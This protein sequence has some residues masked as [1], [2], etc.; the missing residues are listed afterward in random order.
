MD[1]GVNSRQIIRNTI[2]LFD[3]VLVDSDY[4]DLSDFIK[5]FV[6]Q[7]GLY[8][9]RINPYQVNVTKAKL[10]TAILTEAGYERSYH[11]NA[12]TTLNY[13][14]STGYIWLPQAMAE[15]TRDLRLSPVWQKFLKLELFL[16]R[17]DGDVMMLSHRGDLYR[18]AIT[19][20]NYV[21]DAT[22]P[23][24]IEYGFTFEAYT[25]ELGRGR[26]GDAI[27]RLSFKQFLGEQYLP[28]ALLRGLSEALGTGQIK[29][30]IPGRVISDLI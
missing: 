13:R 5:S 3:P 16:E 24:A 12:M 27:K 30:T 23:W 22:R 8:Q 20:F 25:D 29:D 11:G 21:E 6:H 14:G 17:L 9:F 15:V 28:S 1:L 10:T 19:N 18:G 2:V 7:D 26:L 4:E